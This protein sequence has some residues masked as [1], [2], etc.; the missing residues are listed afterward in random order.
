MAFRVEFYRNGRTMMITSNP[1]DLD[2]IIGS[3]RSFADLVPANG[4]V[5]ANGQDADLNPERERQA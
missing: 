1:K 5:I 3:F 2:D 4:L